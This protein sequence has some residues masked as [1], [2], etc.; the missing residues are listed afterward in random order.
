MKNTVRVLEP[1]GARFFGTPTPFWPPDP[2]LGKYFARA[3]K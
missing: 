1:Y 2:G 3:E